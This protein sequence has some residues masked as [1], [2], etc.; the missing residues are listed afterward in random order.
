MYVCVAPFAG[1]WI[2]TNTDEMAEA[3]KAR[4]ARDGFD[5]TR[6]DLKHITI[7]PDPA[8]AQRRTSAQGKTDISILQ[9][10]GFRVVAMSSHPLIRDRVNVVNGKFCNAA[11]KCTVFVDPS[12]K[13]SIKCYEQLTYKEG[14]NE[15]DKSSGLDHIPDATGY[16][17]YARFAYKPAQQTQSTHMG[18]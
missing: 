2:E 12:C 14:T 10:Y 6:P 4:Y 11:G 3:I 7:Y 17:L 5:P 18:R 13:E 1:A 16:Y 9:A 15:P 8:G